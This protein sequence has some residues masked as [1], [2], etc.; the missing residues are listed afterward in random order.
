VVDPGSAGPTTGG[1]A[2]AAGLEPWRGDLDGMVERRCIRVLAVPNRTSYF[3]DKGMARGMT[4]E[5]LT[6][7]EAHVNHAIGKGNSRVAGAIIPVRRDELLPA[8]VEGRAVIAVANPTATAQRLEQVDFGDPLVQNVREVPVTDI[9]QPLLDRPET[10][11]HMTIWVRPSSSDYQSLVDLNDWLSGEGQPPVIIRE[12]DDRVEV[13]DLIEMVNAD[14]VPATFAD[15]H[16]A[17]FWASVLPEVRTH[18]ASAVRTHGA[19]AW[20]IRKQSPQLESAID[21]FVRTWRKGTLFG[22]IACKRY[23]EDNRWVN[24]PTLAE[25]RGRFD[26]MVDR[27]R[28]CS[29]KY[30]LPWVLVAAQAFQESGID[31]SKRDPSGAVGVMQI[32]PST[33]AASPIPISGVETDAARNIE[34]GAKYLRFIVDR[35]YDDSAIGRLDRGLFAVACYNAGNAGPARI[36]RMRRRAAAM[37]LDPNRWFDHVEVAIAEAIGRDTLQ[38][39]SNVQKNATFPARC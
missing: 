38:Y 29:D 31:Q 12:A 25:A 14:P 1:V 35:Y 17:D 3:I 11:S 13:E 24:D 10:L 18:P 28:T 27:F 39:V 7:F 36:D 6:A 26:A 2:R 33:A 8:L 22:N 23:L 32:K 20:A 21:A 15:D 9:S 5:A 4:P 19:I 16:L 30:D 34:A 37:G